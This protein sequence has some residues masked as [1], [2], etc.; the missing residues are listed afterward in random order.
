MTRLFRHQEIGVKKLVDHPHFGLF[1]DMG[2]GKSLTVIEA[3]R[4]LFDQGVIHT[5]IVVCPASVRAVWFDRELGELAKHLSQYPLKVTEF[6][7]R[8]RTWYT[9]QREHGGNLNWVITNYDYLRGHYEEVIK[10]WGGA[11]T[12]MVCDESS[13]LKNDKAKQT[14]AAL[15]LRKAC[16]RVVILNGTPIS[17]NPGDL[18]SQMNILDP[19]ILDLKSSYMFKLRYG[20]MG[21]FEGREVVS[22]RNLEDLQNRIAPHVMRVEKKDCLDLPAKLPPVTLT[23]PLS[24]LAWAKYKEMREEMMVWLDDSKMSTAPQAAVRAI[25]LSQLTSG[26]LGGIVEQITCCFDPEC[27]ACNGT[28]ARLREV[29]AERISSEKLD[30]VTQWLKERLEEDSRFKILIWSRF[31]RE[32]EQLHF[33]LP[34]AF[35]RGIIYGG[36][37]RDERDQALRLLDPRTSPDGPVA[38]IGTPAS[39]S[40]GLNLTAASTVLYISNDYSLK[41]RLQSEDRVHRPGQIHPVSYYDVVATG[42]HGQRTID[43]AVIKALRDK[44]SLANFTVSAWKEALSE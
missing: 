31:R 16:G 33:Q 42:P 30:I 7:S 11:T 34:E 5:V 13:A 3:S 44:E 39:G 32:V 26:F 38:V 36:Q 8:R 41:T 19:S 15:K 14:R 17:N 4:H 6:H 21:G 23:V 2:T 22:W 40:M 35:S 28:G 12:L 37:T 20:V 10:E 25:R 18:Y 1:M 43:H 24:P 9:Q 27:M 29:G